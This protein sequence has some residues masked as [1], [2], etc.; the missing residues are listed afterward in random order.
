MIVF[1]VGQPHDES[2]G[3]PQADAAGGDSVGA[4]APEAAPAEE[5]KP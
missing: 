4:A 2:V 3:S 5:V 1:Q